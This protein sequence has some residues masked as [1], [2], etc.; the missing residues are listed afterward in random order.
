MIKY[1]M[2]PN[3]KELETFKE[4]LILPL[5]DFS[6]G[7]DSYFDLSEIKEI[8][9]TRKVNVMINKFLHSKKIEEIKP[10]IDDLTKYVNLFF[11]EDIGCASLIDREKIVLFQN[12]IVNN[13]DAVNYFNE[14][15]YNKIVINNDL[16]IDELIDI[17]K[18][19]KSELFIFSIN[20]NNLMYS[21]RL[22]LSSYYDYYNLNDKDKLKTIKEKVSKKNLIIKEEDE[23]TTIFNDKIF[24]IN[25]YI[26]KLDDFN[27]IINF[28]NLNS[29][30]T[31]LIK[32]NY[33]SSGLNNLIEVDDYFL[34]NEIIFKVGI[35]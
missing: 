2:I 6:I 35:K 23:S 30:E 15:G 3:S 29:K 11:V 9:K 10:I 13:Y 12:H 16:T 24:S 26:D 20:R 5:K 8:S 19:T 21:R 34:D 31:K 28:S 7:F 14:I 27:F 17:K 22:L 4:E 1:Y 25:K 33:K 18:N 32:E